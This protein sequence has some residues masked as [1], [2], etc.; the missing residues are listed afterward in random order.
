MTRGMGSMS[1]VALIVSVPSPGTLLAQSFPPLQARS[2]RPS[3]IDSLVHHSSLHP[4][5]PGL[6]VLEMGQLI[7]GSFAATTLAD[8]GAEV[9][10]GRTTA[11]GR[12][13][14]QVAPA[15]RRHFGL[16]AGSIAQQALRRAGPEG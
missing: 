5:S 15:E 9:V 8:F 11:G 3:T 2:E 14:S 10:K 13:A 6:K 1:S 12:S 7:A 4:P 16:V